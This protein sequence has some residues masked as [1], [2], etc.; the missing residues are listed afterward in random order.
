M[1]QNNILKNLFLTNYNILNNINLPIYGK[2]LNSR[3][4]IF[5]KDHCEALIEISKGKLKFYNIGQIEILRI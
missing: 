4:W 2:G 1:V 5:V 3:E